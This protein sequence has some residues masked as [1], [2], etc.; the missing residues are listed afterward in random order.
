M[1]SF[2]YNPIMKYGPSDCVSSI[3]A[4]IDKMDQL[5]AAKNTKGIQQF[6]ELFGL[7]ALSDNRD[8]AMTIA[9]P[10]TSFN[11]LTI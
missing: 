3:T 10:S 4:I 5:V 9:F 11:S 1:Y 7:G 2:R 6:K 8:F